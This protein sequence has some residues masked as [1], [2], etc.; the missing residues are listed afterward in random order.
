M[1]SKAMLAT[2]KSCFADFNRR[3]NMPVQV[4]SRAY[5][6]SD[7]ELRRRELAWRLMKHGARTSTIYRFTA[8]S[9][10]QLARLRCRGLVPS[11][12][13]RRGPSPRS[14]TALFRS[15]WSRSESACAAILCVVHRVIPEFPHSSKG[16]RFQS[17]E[18]G[19]RLCDA[20]ET[21]KAR[22][23]GSRLCFERFLS[24]ALALADGVE[25]AL[26]SCECCS[27]IILV[28]LQSTK[29]RMCEMCIE[30]RR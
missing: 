30:S 12:D 3:S 24:L 20:Y 5:R 14:T 7:R 26:A 4:T 16:N 9:R 17:V 13:R 22:L 23:P 11:A 10:H 2:S 29:P 8:L 6:E 28:D 18:Y 1:D 19:E 21:F 25:I 15:P 27:A